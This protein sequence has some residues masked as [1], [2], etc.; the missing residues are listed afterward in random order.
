MTVGSFY[1]YV[2][3]PAERTNLSSN[4]SFELGTIGYSGTGSP[5]LGTSSAGQAFGAW[6]V[7]ATGA[8][9]G[10]GITATTASLGS[11]SAVQQSAFVRI[12]GASGGSVQVGIG[13]TSFRTP[14]GSAWQRVSVGTVQT[15][16]TTRTLAV[17]RYNAAS[18]TLWVDGVQTEYGSITTYLDG[19]QDGC[20]WLGQPHASQSYRNA[21]ARTG[22]TVM[23]LAALGLRA[24]TSPGIGAG[25]VI[26]ISQ[27]RA[28]LDGAEYQR[29][30]NDVRE[31]TLTATITGTTTADLHQT[32]RRVLDALNV[33][34][35]SP[36]APTRFFYTGADGTVQIDAAYAGGLEMND[37]GVISD[38][39]AARFTAFEPTWESV[40]DQGTALSPQV[41][42]GSVAFL[43]WRDPQGRWGTFGAAGTTMGA[44]GTAVGGAAVRIYD[45]NVERP[46]TIIVVGGFGTA[47]G[48]VTTNIARYSNGAWGTLGGGPNSNTYALKWSADLGTVFIGG[49]HVGIG[50]T[51]TRAVGQWTGAGF[52]TFTGGTLTSS[53]GNPTVYDLE[54]APD[55]ALIVVGDFVTAAGTASPNIA[56]YAGG[57]WGTLNGGTL[58]SAGDGYAAAPFGNGNLA[59]AGDFG[60]AGGTTVVDFA[61]YDFARSAWGTYGVGINAD[62]TAVAVTPSQDVYAQS[63][64]TTYRLRPGGAQALTGMVGAS[65]GAGEG[66]LLAFPD[67]RVA[68]G[69]VANLYT[70]LTDI[71]GYAIWNGY[72]WTPPDLYVSGVLQNRVDALALDNQGTFYIGGQFIGP[73]TAAAV[74]SVYNNGM[75]EAYP[76]LRMRNTGSG[77][78]R[79]YQ[80]LN[81]TTGDD[82]YFNLITYPGEYLT[83]DLTPGA[84]A[85]TSNTRGNLISSVLGGSNVATWKLLPG[86]NWLSFFADS[87]SIRA[88]LYWRPRHWSADGGAEST[89]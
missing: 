53:I 78:A 13:G 50:G 23:P 43:A 75:S 51:T 34:R 77:T 32:R 9:D 48:T 71:L 36:Q 72:S 10:L 80:L 19:D 56:R 33:G 4:P 3:V 21:Q 47:G 65:P 79:L 76:V 45:I 89:L 68:V 44:T 42:I 85:F 5:T 11:G 74:T 62:Y 7:T 84:R 63:V 58:A 66:G 59:V 39:A 83:L 87:A 16:T 15:S 24:E 18:G 49:A 35:T 28:V 73:G 41:S 82:I 14:V 64:G 88:D 55:G 20:Q 54:L 25:P 60:G 38:V 37:A 6:A 57:A 31:F 40:F 17:Q 52:G 26:N 86:T 81:T 29:T 46:G 70:T 67:G 27:P 2:V 8:T 22:G 69:R 12:T 61:I 30:R 1:W